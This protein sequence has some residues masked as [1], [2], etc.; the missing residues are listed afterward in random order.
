MKSIWGYLVKAALIPAAALAVAACGGS[1]MP[2]MDHG[3]GNPA[4]SVPLGANFNPADVQFAQM[5][6]PHHRQAVEMADLAATRA[7]DPEIK[8]LAAKIKG[9]QQPEI[10]TM[11]G[12][13]TAWKQP[14]VQA[15]GHNMPGMGAMPGMMSEQDMAALRAA[16]G[17]EFDRQFARM[18]IAHHNGAIQM[19]RDVQKNGSNPDVKN[20]A[21]AI[22]QAQAAEVQQLQKIV[23]RL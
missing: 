17:A 21:S 3:S 12:W 14:S 23:D 1:G 10:D 20:L 8:Q 15:A 18:M 9:A 5:M 4:A 19:A 16:S 11:T 6:I 7:T 13:L 22:E 2:G